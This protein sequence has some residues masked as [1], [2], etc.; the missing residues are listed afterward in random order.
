VNKQYNLTELK[1]NDIVEVNK[2]RFRVSG[3][4]LEDED[5]PLELTLEGS[6]LPLPL[7]KC[8]FI[9]TAN[10]PSVYTFEVPDEGWWID[11]DLLVRYGIVDDRALVQPAF[12][13]EVGKCY[14]TRSGRKAQVI[15]HDTI[16][17]SAMYPF[18]GVVFAADGIFRGRADSWMED[19]RASMTGESDDDLVSLITNNE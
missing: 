19:G 12:R 1:L 16:T 7:P 10:H 4:D 8:L 5:Q 9:A 17:P 3:L 18:K 2:T 15:S 13:I 6:D 11:T 14:L